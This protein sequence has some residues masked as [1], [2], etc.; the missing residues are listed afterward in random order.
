MINAGVA[1]IGRIAVETHIPTLKKLFGF[2]LKS[3]YDTTPKRREVGAK[4]YKVKAYSRYRDFLNSGIDLVI[5][6][7][8]SD[9]HKTLAVDALRAGKHVIVEKPMALTSEEAGEM[10]AEARRGKLLLTVHHNRRW[11]ADFLTI[12]KVFDKGL[13]GK[14]FS[15]ESRAN[16]FGS[17]K[18]Y[19]V[20]EFDTMWRYKKRYGG[21][22]LYDFGSHLIDQVLCLLRDKL[23]SVF[24]DTESVHWSKETEDYARVMMR[25]EGGLSAMIEVSQV[26]HVIAPRWVILG[27]KG[28]LI[29]Y[30]DRGPVVVRYQD[31]SGRIKEYRPRMERTN[32]LSFY[33]NIRD[34][35]LKNKPLCVD[36]KEARNVIAVIEAAKRSAKSGKSERVAL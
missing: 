30:S 25:F 13:L 35:L 11:D 18:G 10:A 4:S 12:K 32:W 21:G 17:L 19:A 23:V 28:S 31:K 5:I 8:P 26:S 20:K 34:H 16:S 24:C 7:T 14:V 27:T 3:L 1:G 29:A 33:K 22:V 6:A 36:P 15:I 9:S 2:R